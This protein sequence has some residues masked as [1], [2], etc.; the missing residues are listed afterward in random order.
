M[1]LQEA[2]LFKNSR[3]GIMASIILFTRSPQLYKTVPG[4]MS[5]D[6]WCQGTTEKAMNI[7]NKLGVCLCSTAGRAAVD[8]IAEGYKTGMLEWKENMEKVTHHFTY[9]EKFLIFLPII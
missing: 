6:L 8:H 7:L 4:I 5:V 2:T 9:T 3:L 1:T